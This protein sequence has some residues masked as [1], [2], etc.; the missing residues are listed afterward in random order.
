MPKCNH[1]E[2]EVGT[3]P[4]VFQ[5]GDKV[6]LRKAHPC[7]GD[8]WEVMRVGMDFRLRC[9]TC[10]R[11]MMISRPKFEKAVKKVLFRA[12]ESEGAMEEH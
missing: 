4:G 2:T 10:G 1:F 5:I 9:L 11:V 12:N 7:G 8:T 3:V 6:Q